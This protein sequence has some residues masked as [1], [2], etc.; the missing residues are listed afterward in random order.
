MSP[1][2]WLLL[3]RAAL[4][5]AIFASAALV[6]D[7]RNLADASFCGTESDCFKVRS[8][9]VG[10]RIADAVHDLIPGATLP[11]VALPVFAGVLAVTLFLQSRRA[12]QVLAGVTLIGA[13]TA[14]SLVYVQVSIGAFCAYCMI[15]DTSAVVAAV[16]ALMIAR[17]TKSDADAERL[18]GPSLETRVTL[19]WGIAGA[20]VTALPYLWAEF[21][22][23]E[24]LPPALARHQEPG[25]LTIISFTDFQCPFCRRLHGTMKEIKQREDVVL[26]R[27][28]VPLDGHPGAMP[29]AVAYAC[30]GDGKQDAMAD[31]LYGA[32]DHE[33]TYEGVVHILTRVTG[34]EEAAVRK[35]MNDPA[36]KQRVADEKKLFE[37]DLA[38]SGLPTTFVGNRRIRGAAEE[39]ILV[40]ART[41]SAGLE[42]PVSLL[43][44]VAGAVVLGATLLTARRLSSAPAGAERTPDEAAPK[45]APPEP[46]AD[47]REAER[48]DETGAKA[49]GEE[50]AA[51][52]KAPR[53]DK[54]KK[55]RKRKGSASSG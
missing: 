49:E 2:R 33:L 26:V 35:C 47:A 31:A 40:A 38:L 28:M 48:A 54:Q 41:A 13:L 43:F 42:L 12:T 19:P 37:V 51:P 22:D 45:E 52:A 53:G 17:A 10:Q 8:S 55:A 14:L 50:A 9:D 25:K 20:L 4:C 21:P 23:V 15:V 29:A 39:K 5:A 18:L 46:P 36:T 27:Y 32:P 16:G 3:V 30:A 24:P 44:V 34:A 6:I 7:Y 11:S 1:A